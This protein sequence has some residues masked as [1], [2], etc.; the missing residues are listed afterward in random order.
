M[1]RDQAT[2]RQFTVRR[3]FFAPQH[4]LPGFASA[5]GI[6]RP[7]CGSCMQMFQRPPDDGNRRS[8]YVRH[9]LAV[10][11]AVCVQLRLIRRKARDVEGLQEKIQYRAVARLTPG[12]ELPHA[13]NEGEQG[14][15][16]QQAIRDVLF[17][18]PFPVEDMPFPVRRNHDIL[19]DHI[20]I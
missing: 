20:V 19:R 16:Q 9:D 17:A 12:A 14:P 4:L 2:P 10:Q 11:R 6:A 13:R 3:M 7:G 18:Q 15:K 8:G 5:I 1:G